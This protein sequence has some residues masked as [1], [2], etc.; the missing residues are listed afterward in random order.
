[1][2]DSD[3]SKLEI[4]RDDVRLAEIAIDQLVHLVDQLQDQISSLRDRVEDLEKRV[5]NP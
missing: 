2:T 4:V 3:K 5:P 1:M